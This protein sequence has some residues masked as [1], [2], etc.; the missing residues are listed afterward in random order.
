MT[1]RRP[2]QASL[3]ARVDTLL[4]QAQ[5]ADCAAVVLVDP[6]NQYWAS[7]YNVDRDASVWERPCALILPLDGEPAFVLNEICE[8]HAQLSIDLGWCWVSDCQY[9]LERPSLNDDVATIQEWGK[10]VAAVLHSRKLDNQ[11]IACDDPDFFRARMTNESSKVSIID[12]SSWTRD[13]RMVKDH[14]EIDTLRAA[15]QLTDDAMSDFRHV[16]QPGR[17]AMHAA[18]E[19]QHRL[20]VQASERY[21]DA[22]VEGKVLAFTGLDS[23]CVNAPYGFAGRRFRSG[24][25]VITVVIL[26][27]NGYSAENERTFFVDG[28][29]DEQRQYFDVAVAAQ[30]AGRLAAVERNPI[31]AIDAA[32]RSVIESADLGGFIK[33]RTGHGIGLSGH[34]PP[35]DMA[36]NATLQQSGMLFSVEPGLYVPG[37]GGFRHSDT[38]LVGKQPESLTQFGRTIDACL[39]Q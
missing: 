32:A 18:W 22:R 8:P 39:A 20:F 36:F 31:S 14:V 26:S 2:D 7:G 33:H 15:A 29:S 13:A 6:L 17:V 5:S 25:S 23:V 3:R 10:L 12:A 1:L 34:E 4:H 35:S 38:V 30:E 16:I 21:P 28:C 24:D 9:Y 19:I 27:L 37:V 11:Q